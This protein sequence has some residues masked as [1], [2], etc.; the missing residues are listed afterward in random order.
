[1][2][3]TRRKH[4]LF[5]GVR[6][7]DDKMHNYACINY[8]GRHIPAGP[9]AHGLPAAAAAIQWN[10]SLWASQETSARQDIVPVAMSVVVFL[11]PTPPL[12]PRS[13][14]GSPSALLD[15]SYSY[16]IIENEN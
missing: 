16:R 1:M 15:V 9:M 12:S 3:V 4:L 5:P 8:S 7:G 10:G 2:H 13:S 14:I 6:F 11:W